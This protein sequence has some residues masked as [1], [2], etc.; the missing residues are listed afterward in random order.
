MKKDMDILLINSYAPRQR[1]AS[2]AGLE[3]GLAI[4]RTYLEDKG[5]EVDVVDEQGIS[6]VEQGVPKWCLTLL[7]WLTSIQ[8]KVYQ[9]RFKILNS[10]IFMA[11][12][13]VQTLSLYCRRKQMESAIRGIIDQIHIKHIPVIGIKVWY[14]DA[15]RWSMHLASRVRSEC[16]NCVIIAGGP[17][18][19]VYGEKILDDN[20]F[21]LAIVG[22]G[23]VVLAQLLDLRHQLADR[24]EFLQRVASDVSSTPIIQA[25]GYCEEAVIKQQEAY[26]MTIARY[27]QEDLND[28]IL[29][30]TLVDGFGCSWKKCNFCTHTRQRMQY[31]PRPVD[32]IIAEMKAMTQYGIGFFRFSSSETPLYHGKEIAQAIL[33]EGLTVNYSMFKRPEK[34]VSQATYEAY[35]IMIKSGLRAVF[36]GG[37]T[38]HDLVNEVVMNK[39]VC[40][41]DIVNTI[42]CIKL[43]AEKAGA[44]CRIGLSLIYPSPIIAGITLQDVY[45]E[46]MSLIQETLPDTVIVNPP[47]VFPATKWFDNAEQFGFTIGQDFVHNLMRY[48]YSIYKPAEL[49][50]KLNYTLNGMSNLEL[51]KET[52]KLRQAVADM[53]IP[54]DISDEYLMMT[55]AIGYKS[56][57]DLLQFKRDSLLDIMTGTASYAREMAEKING[58]S[59]CIASQNIGSNKD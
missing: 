4:I 11:T 23:E 29:F 38:G 20:D 51:L 24:Q 59:R 46:N 16:P 32:E 39:G 40:R 53:G 18:A 57:L 9:D 34:V 42:H 41:K 56:K 28:K 37:E 21:D 48:E 13:A 22:P 35:R 19:K 17:Q 45:Q 2:D 26:K 12:F 3:N 54:T 10:L 1:I 8:I 52:G 33:N 14:G 6:S 30:H 50:D 58:Q 55:E 15:F 43:A 31:Q 25:W 49:W 7:R 27:R 47:I 36:M 5:F 44:S